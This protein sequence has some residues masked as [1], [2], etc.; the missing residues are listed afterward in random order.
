MTET[1]GRTVAPAEILALSEAE[2][3]TYLD[4]LTR[5]V[6]LARLSQAYYPSGRITSNLE[7][8]Q[9][10]FCMGLYPTL[11][12]LRRSGLPVLRDWLRPIVDRMAAAERLGSAHAM[13]TADVDAGAV[14]ARRADY[15]RRLLGITMQPLDTTRVKIRHVDKQGVD[16]TVDFDR[17]DAR[18]LLVRTTFR[19]RSRGASPKEGPTTAVDEQWAAPVVALLERTCSLEPELALLSLAAEESLTVESVS[20]GTVGPLWRAGVDIP[21]ELSPAICGTPQ[22]FVLHCA[23]EL[24]G[25]DV[26][27]TRNNDPFA[28]LLEAGLSAE[29]EGT[30]VQLQ[31]KL[32]YR[33]FKD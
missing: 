24:A 4:S 30:C 1:Q 21:P 10:S 31:E 16:L 33:A 25:I 29:S 26:P 13:R 15:Y 2:Q 17:L 9:P 5:A 8:L 23:L 28:R 3:V 19:A 14:T 6:R 22:G 20:R 12:L 11:S 18:G 27:E 32:S 7:L